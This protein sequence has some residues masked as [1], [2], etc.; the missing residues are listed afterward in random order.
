[1]T[2][3]CEIGDLST[4]E[5]NM[6]NGVNK[7]K[8]TIPPG[9]S[10]NLSLTLPS[11]LGSA[12]TF[13][14]N[15]GSSNLNWSPAGSQTSLVQTGF[16]AQFQATNVNYDEKI[17]AFPISYTLTPVVLATSEGTSND[18]TDR[19]I[20]SIIANITTTNFTYG[21]YMKYNIKST[22]S[23]T[24]GSNYDLM[25]N[26]HKYQMIVYINSGILYA[27]ANLAIDATGYWKIFTIDASVGSTKPSLVKLTNLANGV[28]YRS[29]TNTLQWAYNYVNN[30]VTNL[31]DPTVGSGINP[32]VKLLSNGIPVI[33]ALNITNLYTYLSSNLSGTGTWLSNL[34][35]TSVVSFDFNYL[36]T[37]Y[38]AIIYFDSSLGQ[39]TMVTNTVD[40]MSGSWSTINV[41]T[42]GTNITSISMCLLSNGNPAC[43]FYDS[44][45]N[46][47]KLA[48][49]ANPTGTSWNIYMIN[50]NGSPAYITILND[51]TPA[52]AYISSNVL[53]MTK[54]AAID[55]SGIWSTY[56]INSGPINTIGGFITDLNQLPTVAYDDGTSLYYEKSCLPTRF[57]S[58]TN[59][60]V[61]WISTT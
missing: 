21:S 1:M 20:N 35:L 43:V 6:R 30:W 24:A 13:L 14:A 22:I 27:A 10:S 32:K 33:M 7:F 3:V 36:S 25:I 51:G 46:N 2:S 41:I 5:V 19:F 28:A 42:T 38:P 11:T 31:V 34:A 56:T 9:M 8:L 23:T 48:A 61:N 53:Y 47:L 4:S 58:T 18:F 54:N 40:D 16:P 60:N 44:S 39:L 17:I 50:A 15:N 59:Y 26:G 57:P 37:N 29:S 55:G 49:S 45:N 52:I 12:S